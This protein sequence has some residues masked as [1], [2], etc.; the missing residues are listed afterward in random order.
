M[1]ARQGESGTIKLDDLDIDILRSLNGNARKS[2]RDIAKEL[3]V[4][5]TTVSNRV[6]ALE[7]NGVIQ[8][9]IPVVDATKL[10][11]DIMAVIGI[12]VIHGKIV[13][14]E[15]DLAKE[16]GVFA[17]FDS[18]GEWDAIVMARFR[19]RSELNTFVKKVLD[20]ENVDRTYTQVVL[21]IT[22]DEKRVLV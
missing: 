19:N 5:L 14:T 16:E 4:S 11:Y 1:T 13:E 15:R 12:K 18:T 17:V 3:H 7:K 22:R 20:H 21:N 6:K 8:G 10:G 2:F 9:Y